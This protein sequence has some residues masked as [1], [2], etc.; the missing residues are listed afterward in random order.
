MLLYLKP[1]RSTAARRTAGA[2][3]PPETEKVL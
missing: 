2:D 3:A 1:Q